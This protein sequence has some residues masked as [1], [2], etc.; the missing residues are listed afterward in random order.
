MEIK[1]SKGV[2]YVNADY[3]IEE[4]QGEYPKLT[5]TIPASKNKS[6]I[7]DCKELDRLYTPGEQDEFVIINP[8]KITKGDSYDLEITAVGA[9][10]FD[11]VKSR[12]DDNLPTRSYTVEYLLDLVFKDTR[13]SYDLQG[14]YEKREFTNFGSDNRYKLFLQIMNRFN[15]EFKIIGKIVR[16]NSKIGNDTGFQ[17]RYLKN[18]KDTKYSVD[19]TNLV[20]HVKGYGAYHD[21]NDQSKGRLE[22]EYLSPLS[23]IYGKLSGEP[24]VDERMSV[25]ATLLEKCKQSVESSVA[26][27]VSTTL[28]ALKNQ[29]YRGV[30]RVGDSIWFIDE[31]IELEKKIRFSTVKSYY[32]A[33][34][35]LIKQDVQ[36]GDKD[37][38]SRAQ[39]S[40]SASQSK[41]IDMQK[42]LSDQLADVEDAIKKTYVMPSGVN[43][44]FYSS[45]LP[46]DVPKGTIKE[47]DTLFRNIDGETKMYRWDGVQWELVPVVNDVEKFREELDNEI[48]QVEQS[49]QTQ[50]QEHDRQVADILSKTQSVESLANQAKSDAASALAR[51]NQVKTEA[52]A[53]ARAQV[54]T[55]S[56]ALNTAKTELQSAIASA[57]Q[58]ARD[59][60]ASA[61]ALRND[62]DLQA[63]KI[64][65]Q[66][67][68]QTDLSNRVSTVETL[69]DGT[70]S[71]VAELSK[72]VA[73]AT[74][75]ITS[76]TSRTKTVEDT[77]SQTRTQYEAL[78]Q[79]VNTQT[80]Q[81]DSIN[82]K[83]ADLQ[84]GID[85]V[86][87][88]FENL[89][90]GGENYLLNSNFSGGNNKW[91]VLPPINTT[92]DGRRFVT[93]PKS[94]FRMAQR[95]S[96]ESGKR[97]L[98]SFYARKRNDFDVD[99]VVT[100]KFDIL[101]N[102]DSTRATVNSTDWRRYTVEFSTF[103]SGIELIYFLNRNS[104][105]VDISE[106]IKLEIGD[107]PTDWS[108]AEEDLR[109]EIATYKRTA[110]ES[111][112]ELSRQIQ[113]VD[114]KAVDA[115][116]Y[117]QQTADA[118]KT[119]LESLEIYKN[120]EGDR[121]EQ[122]LTASREETARQLSAERAAI[123]TNYV[124]KSTYDENVR[125][126]TLKLNEI[127][128]T[129]D[130]AKQNLATY[131]NAV[132]RKL[133]EL[134]TSTQTLD[135][136]I[137][138]ASAKV[139][140]VAG[141][142]RTEIGE[143]EG[144]IPNE[145]GGRNYILK[146]QAEISS[147]GRWVS[148]PF[149]L[150][151]DLLSNLSKI[152]TVTISC[153]V[154]GTN[155]STINSRKR[156]GLACSVEINGIVNYWE[157][158]QTQ[159][160]TKK[161]I[162]Q[163][164]TVPEGKVITKFHLPTL[165]IQAVGDIKVSNPKIEFGRVP[166]DHTLAP[167]DITNEISSIKTTITQTASGVEQLSTSL[168][169]TDNKVT[170]AEAKIRNL[171][172]EVSSKVS[173]TDYNTLTGRVDDNDTAIAQNATEISKR[174]TSTQ[175]DKAITDKGYQTASQVNTAITAKGYQTKSDVDSNI[176]GRGYITNS[177][178]QPY[179]LST[180]V[181][182]LVKETADSFSR[183][184]SETKALI[185]SY[186]GTRN[187]LKGT[188]DLSG[189][190]AKNFNT[191]DKYL[192]F[193]IA[194][195]R[196]TTGYSDTFSAY[197]TIPVTANDYII[198]F[199][200]KSDVDGA[201]LY[202]HFHNPNTTTKA[203]S[204]TGYKGGSPDGLAR[205]QVTTEWQRYWVKW[206][207]SKTDTVKRV[208]IGRNNSA[209]GIKIIEV[210]GVALYEGALNKGHFDAPEDLATVTALHNV[211]DTVSSHTRTIG[212]VGETGSILDNVSKVTQT[213]AGLVQEVSGTNGLK[214]QVSTLAGSYAVKNL[215][216]SGDILSQANL[217]SA[218]FLL[219]AAKIRL[220]GKT[221]ADEIQAIDGKFKTLFV[222]D[223][224]FAKLNAAVIDSQAITA[225]K[226]KVDQAF[227]DKLMA[228]DAYLRQL[229]AKSAFIT[230]VQAVTLSA[231]QIAGG[232]AKALNG[233]MDV[234][235]DE[236]KINF[237]T[238]VA[239]IRRIYT[240][241]PTQFIK[242][243][244]EGN[245]SRTIIGSNRNGGEVFN[246]ATFAGIVVEN[247]NNIN[248]EDSVRIY[249]DN[250]LFRHAQGDVGWNINSVTQRIVPA[251]INAESEIWSKHFVAP[252]KNSKP[253]RLDTAVAAL[254]DIWNH[255]I[256]NN[257]E[258][259]EALRTHIKARRDNW[260]FELNL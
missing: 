207:Q 117:A 75:D 101:H 256:Y 242:F 252:D 125:G 260:K 37:V 136:K 51:A 67:R 144:K 8:V 34:D 109:S 133:T 174:L 49:M 194:R 218:Q 243:E 96:V 171:V 138:T 247:T 108:P 110:E 172:N 103:K 38:F 160:T 146:S 162:S 257:F 40:D 225:D 192:D 206:S 165:W 126:T 68:A 95:V 58:K 236:S 213:A 222:A 74:G 114:G 145:V 179:A 178:L 25:S 177:A 120:A 118:I 186:V 216:S 201:T 164:F 134:T 29:E 190:D 48:A 244:T 130:T 116:T 229:F 147:A 137:N 104:I 226:L 56:Q 148:K 69:A 129:A 234:N 42:E 20:T 124:A 159:D 253:V 197:T 88:R 231:K 245:Y 17:F 202:C 228:D 80:G 158:W 18:I 139:D 233:G 212:A 169:T 246:S 15:L 240:G 185:P 181:Q 237:Y 163:T 211:K 70:R 99:P 224:T 59:S 4:K 154:E 86:T 200:A 128:T 54:A 47:G 79:T 157:V 7:D 220:K 22:V 155:V 149:N 45:D 219:E 182:T 44:V 161:R 143:V 230:Q 255:I 183:T 214:T 12:I 199:Y 85:G 112:V 39:S 91:H 238:N 62:L 235:F 53:D 2:Y 151:S 132:D 94:L 209:D 27:T 170:T 115:K 31:R 55:V 241:H 221:L 121:A 188:K 102:A 98:I 193:N 21:A 13:Y 97:Y 90:I 66:A 61:T 52:I 32:D 141:Q 123:A 131:Q 84:S 77:L 35:E 203:E 259:N 208:I 152:K 232:I 150:S 30:A 251:N 43:R 113:L 119:R 28:V 3:T 16:I 105:E 50:A 9:F 11:F 63:S 33:F 57:D 156:Y 248:T 78:T 167:E 204:S 122:Y 107:V 142:I 205:V 87:E 127:K 26:V 196:P 5:C 111:S 93:L 189:N 46:E 19:A 92:S 195:S 100:V 106:K 184:I 1:T 60:Q 65:E 36:L 168:A 223:G 72:T 254:W 217:S 239:A 166:T 176:R 83:T 198:S 249:G 73:K 227:F 135:G 81:I 41:L 187:L 89:Q 23:D 140:T 180:T 175:V 6:W 24:V 173:Q 250:T 76:V 258:F 14:T 10:E 191:S 82:R 71:T 210:A 215:N 153:D 64:L